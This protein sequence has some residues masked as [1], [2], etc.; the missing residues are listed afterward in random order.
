MTQLVPFNVSEATLDAVALISGHPKR[1]TAFESFD[2][3]RVPSEL[4]MARRW[5]LWKSVP[6][7]GSKARK[8][9]YYAD[10][11][12]RSGVLDGPDDHARLVSAEEALSLW[13]ADPHAYAGLGFALGPDGNGTVWQGIDLDDVSAKPHL[14]ELARQ[15]PGF[16][17]RSPSGG[18]WH[19]IGRGRQFPTLG[20]NASGIEAYCKGRFFTFTTTDARGHDLECLADFV[21]RTLLPMHRPVA[22]AKPAAGETPL[23]STHGVSFD[24][25]KQALDHLDPDDY[26]EWIGIGHAL[27]SGGEK[28]AGL[29][30]QWSSRSSKFDETD[31]RKRWAGFLPERTSLASIL[32]RARSR[33]RPRL[34]NSGGPHGYEAWT[35]DPP[36][37]TEVPLTD[38]H[39]AGDIQHRFWWEGYVPASVLTLLAA[40][41]GTGKSMLALHLA[42]AIA[43]GRPLFGVPT[44]PGRVAFFSGEDPGTLVKARIAR[45]CK[46]WGLSE[47]LLEDRL[48][49]LDGTD[50]CP[51]L[52]QQPGKGKPSQ[53]TSTYEEL[54]Q[55]VRGKG[56]DVVIVDNASETYDADEN[57]RADV[58][59]FN[60]ILRR[61]INEQQGAV[62]LIA[63]VD[64]A[65]ARGTVPGNE[66]YSGSTAWHNSARSRLLL[67]TIEGGRLKLSQLKLNVGR[68]APPLE[69]R[70]TE[71][72]VIVSDCPS[73]AGPHARYVDDAEATRQ[74]LAFIHG[75]YS[76]EEWISPHR[77][78]KTA[79]ESVLRRNKVRILA[80]TSAADLAHQAR[81][82]GLIEIEEYRSQHRKRLERLK[83]TDAG[84]QALHS[85]A[86]LSVLSGDALSA[87]CAPEGA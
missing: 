85:M 43:V 70:W 21:E 32:T 46:D 87:P 48:F 8:V 47:A 68:L 34:E 44:R 52:M 27:K 49:L 22:A 74:I 35:S 37:F 2:P 30:L 29:W 26:D 60:L 76:N 14:A 64:K 16:V 3:S 15:L 38:L 53:P 67:E 66:S 23:S 7:N 33:T 1:P 4:W 41:G 18:G 10:G 79:I 20:S 24:E 11:S 80:R 51:V 28:Y 25:L 63:H 62:V 40:H 6:N 31:A 42:L 83:L 73:A 84:L 61:L 13:R 55:Y 69:L 12:R 65:S 77:N 78:A 59:R 17:H 5:L 72:G 58:R 56:I 82:D 75:R 54:A 39:L 86:D 19:A 50:G 45:I 36:N 9:P 71:D 57:A 81:Q